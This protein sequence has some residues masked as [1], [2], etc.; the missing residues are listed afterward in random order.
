MVRLLTALGLSLTFLIPVAQASHRM[1]P[2]PALNIVESGSVHPWEARPRRHRDRFNVYPYLSDEEIFTHPS[3]SRTH[4][5]HPYH[6]ARYYDTI[7]Y[8]YQFGYGRMLVRHLDDDRETVPL[9]GNYTFERPNYRVP[10]F[11]YECQ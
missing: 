7:V 9:C 6:R 10:P 1:I 4:A 3:R 11:G 5:L 8:D 2:S